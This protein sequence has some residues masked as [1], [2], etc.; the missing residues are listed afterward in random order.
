V[1]RL[2][3]LLLLGLLRLACILAALLLLLPGK[4]GQQAPRAHVRGAAAAVEAD[5]VARTSGKRAVC[6]QLRGRRQH[7][8][9]ASAVVRSAARGVRRRVDWVCSVACCSGSGCAVAATAPQPLHY[10][11]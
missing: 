5:Q 4:H 7:P 10:T 11:P 1:A 9:T 3:L 8:C 6:R 2:L